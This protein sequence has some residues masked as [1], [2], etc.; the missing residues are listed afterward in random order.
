MK[1]K[2]IIIGDM[3]RKEMKNKKKIISKIVLRTSSQM[4]CGGVK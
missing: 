3:E 4:Y 2:K 1:S